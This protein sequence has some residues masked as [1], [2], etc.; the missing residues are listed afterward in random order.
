MKILVAEDDRITRTRILSYLREWGHDVAEVGDGEAA[1]TEFQKGGTDMI[2]TDWQMPELD[3]TQLLE[4]VRSEEELGFHAYAILLTSRSEKQDIV[5]GLE[6]GAD[7]FVT[8]PFDKDELRARIKAGER[9]IELEAALAEKNRILAEANQ[10]MT[11]NLL[12]AATIQKSFLPDSLPND[13]R[14]SFAWHYE[15]C[16]ELAGDTLNVVK[17]G[18]SQ[19]A[20]YI[21]DV[22]GHGVAAALMSVHLSRAL[23]RTDGPDTILRKPWS[24]ETSSRVIEAPS[25]VAKR[26]NRRFPYDVGAGQYF[27]M[28]YGVLDLTTQTFTYTSAGHPGPIVISGSEATVYS[29][30]PPGIGLIS[31]AEFVERTV[32]LKSGDR[33]YLYTDGA[34]EVSNE[35]GEELGEQRL[36]DVL[37]KVANADTS[38]DDDLRTILETS[39]A[40]GGGA[41]F[42]DDFSLLA[43]AIS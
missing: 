24:P 25:I 16:D 29:A 11:K 26:L 27:T 42:D 15:P 10:R 37:S 39:R 18:D 6:C 14:V 13:D 2:I 38:L 9:I 41:P 34:F 12:A 3:G 7:D 30:S 28:I 17:L 5:T 31:D 40:W 43:T 22:S 33:L 20:V 36:A 23:T 4:R 1:W 21:A 8:K 35:E 19:F 32:Q